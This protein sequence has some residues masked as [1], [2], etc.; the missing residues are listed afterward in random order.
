MNAIYKDESYKII[1]A[2]MEVHKELGCGFLEAVYQEALET[3]FKL[4]NIPYKREVSLQIPYKGHILKQPYYADFVCYDKI[5]IE[6]KA[7]DTLIAKN[8]S[9]VVNYLEATKFRLGLLINFGQ[10]SLQ[11]KRLVRNIY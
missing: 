3:E 8:E 2:C 10:L 1:G 4:Q 6:T 11:Q 9:Q 7:T 5:I